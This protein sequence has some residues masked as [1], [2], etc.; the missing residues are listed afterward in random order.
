MARVFVT[1]LQT[2][3][4]APCLKNSSNVGFHI[5]QKP[6]L[7]V[8]GTPVH[9]CSVKATNGSVALVWHSFFYHFS[10]LVGKAEYLVLWWRTLGIVVVGGIA[11]LWE[12][13]GFLRRSRRCGRLRIGGKRWW[14]C[15]G[16]PPSLRVLHPMARDFGRG[17][18]ELSCCGRRVLVSLGPDSV[19]F[20]EQQLK[21]C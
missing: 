13:A 21:S 3:L 18:E 10:G 15:T 14:H 17:G 16:Y 12:T 19:Q 4:M 1:T 6:D 5:A 7:G 2:S 8:A 9:L 11:V 20:G